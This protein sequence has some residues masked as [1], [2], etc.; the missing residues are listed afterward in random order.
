[1]ATRDIL[2]SI[3]IT[4]QIGILTHTLWKVHISWI[5][6]KSFLDLCNHN[7]QNHKSWTT[8]V[9]IILLKVLNCE[10]PRSETWIYEEPMRKSYSFLPNNSI[11]PTTNRPNRRNILSWDFKEI[12]IDIVLNISP[13][14]SGNSSDMMTLVMI[15]QTRARLHRHIKFCPFFCFL[16]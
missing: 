16:Q 9:E 3:Y 2:T 8:K 13:T 15:W 10:K 12:P 11:S 4:I 7:Y 1:M 14:M 6:R 5:P